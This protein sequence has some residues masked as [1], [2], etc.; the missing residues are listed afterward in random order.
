MRMRPPFATAV[1]LLAACGDL[2]LRFG[3]EPQ[4]LE[5]ASLATAKE[6]A[7]LVAE[8]PVTC[9]DPSLRLSVPFE[10]R[11]HV[12]PLSGVTNWIWA[13]GGMVADLDGDGWLDI[14]A[15]TE[16]TASLYHNLLGV[17]FPETSTLAGFNLDFG[18]GGSAADFDA[19]GDLDLLVIRC[20][21]PTALL[22]NEGNGSFVDVTSAA[23]IYL[24]CPA[25]T[26]SWA[27]ADGDLDLDLF[28]G[29]TGDAEHYADT[30]A[31][32]GFPSALYFNNGDGSFVDQSALIPEQA[33]GAYTY[34]GGFH[35]LDGDLWPDLY[36]VNDYG[37]NGGNV[38]LTNVGGSFVFEPD[39]R[40]LDVVV[41]GTGLGAEDING[42]GNPDFLVPDWSD[43][44]L[45]ES[46]PAGWTD[47]A[48]ARGLQP[49]ADQRVAWGTELGDMNNDGLIDAVVA[50]GFTSV[51]DP[52]PLNTQIQPDALF[53]QQP[54]GTFVDEADAWDF[55]DVDAVDGEREAVISN[56]GVV[57]A[58]LNNDGFL[59]VVKRDLDGPNVLYLSNCGAE[60]WL[61]VR[62]HHQGANTF[63]IGAVVTVFSGGSHWQRTV[64]AGGT[65][66]SS[67]GPPEVHFGL[68]EI[69]IVDKID[70]RW[71][72]G[73]VTSF[74]DVDTRQTLD[75]FRQ[76]LP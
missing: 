33:Q 59:D 63:G 2:E 56:R 20:H 52:E 32:P 47:T 50:Y 61:R 37:Q 40:G 21:E 23:G 53:L 3:V 67:S 13:G 1:V 64:R 29:C 7:W 45:L 4:L 46:G 41:A 28:I 15:P 51:D 34:A 70:V 12:V 72:D 65:S 60:A 25:Q 49:Q 6:V 17:E 27:D 31:A 35:D 16:T 43:L 54:D 26:S 22:R 75:V 24:T 58:D 44:R 55:A 38:A 76:P 19:D 69:G 48:V 73:R 42:D 11:A 8:G 66:Y 30:N 39:A 10:R 57:L 71:P 18:A 62:L 68:A 36:F 14:V 5:G 74:S 9:E